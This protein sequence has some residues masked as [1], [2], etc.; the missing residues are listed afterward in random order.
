MNPDLDKL[1]PYPFERLVKLKQGIT[2]PTHLKHIALSIGEPKHAPPE[3]VLQTLRENLD[4][5]G[6]YPMAKGLPELRQAIARWLT[7]RFHLKPGHVDPER[8][9]IPVSG[10]REGLFAFAQAVVDRSTKPLV[11]MPNPF[12]QIYE[13]AAFLAGAEPYFMDTLEEHGFLPDLDAVPENVWKRCQLLYICTPGNPTGAVMDTAYLK[14]VVE[15]ADRY[16]FVVASDECYAEIY[17][18]EAWPPAGLLQACEEMGRHDFKRCVVFHSLS[19]RSSLPGLRSGFVAGDADILAKFL[20]YR[21]YHGCAVPVPVQIASIRAWDDDRHVLKNRRLYQAKFTAAMEILG[22]V[23]DVHYPP[24]AFYLWPRTP[25]DDERFAQEL[26]A[27]QN[28]TA[29]PGSYLSRPGSKGD[30]GKNRLRISL[31]TPLAECA[32]AAH[33]IRACVESL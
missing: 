16:G 12:Y 25:I 11:L 7:R 3:F 26:F 28:V 19:K 5:L 24:A 23:M 29:L 32:E 2:P 22:S 6:A 14:H 17:L 21:T 13:G 9:V 1:F 33:R 10:T 31:V 8:H 18:D 15:L 30:P 27:R 4:G 20:L